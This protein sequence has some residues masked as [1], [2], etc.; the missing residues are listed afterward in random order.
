[1]LPQRLTL[2]GFAVQLHLVGLHHLLDGLSDVA[3][4]HVDAGVLRETRG[5]L[6]RL[7]S[8]NNTKKKKHKTFSVRCRTCIPV[9]VASFTAS[10]SLSY[11]G[12]NV[13]VKAQSIILPVGSKK[14]S[15]QFT[16]F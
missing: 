3:Q 1:M 2:V 16:A 11:F 12:L 13:T 9:L 7:R 14:H 5:L 4:A 15:L 10:N 6:V 8:A